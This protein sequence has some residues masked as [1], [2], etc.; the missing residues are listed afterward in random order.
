VFD[1]EPPVVGGTLGQ[2]QPNTYDIIGRSFFI[3]ARAR[4]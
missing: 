4:F 2:T 3:A 1:V